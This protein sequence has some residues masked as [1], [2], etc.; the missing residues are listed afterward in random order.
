LV[1]TLVEQNK[2]I[3]DKLEANKVTAQ[4]ETQETTTQTETTET[5]V[6]NASTEGKEVAATVTGTE[7]NTISNDGA[8][9]TETTQKKVVINSYAKTISG[10]L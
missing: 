5:T 7:V 9:T 1:S 6:E 2:A 10:Q 3:L 8:G 4:G